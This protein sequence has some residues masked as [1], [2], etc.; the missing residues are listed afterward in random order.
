MASEDP[1][2]RA[3]DLLAALERRVTTIVEETSKTHQGLP[4]PVVEQALNERLS[5]ELP[6]ARFGASDIREWAA[7]IS[8]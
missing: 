1:G 4:M 7:T 2:A 3:T 6:E 8:S 5:L